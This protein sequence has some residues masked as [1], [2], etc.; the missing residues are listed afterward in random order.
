MSDVPG[1]GTQGLLRFMGLGLAATATA[2]LL[3]Y[4]PTLQWSGGDGIRAM[5]AGCG[6]ALVAGWIGAIPL[7]FMGSLGRGAA[8][9]VNRIL[10]GSALRM[11]VA[12]AL[13]LSLALGGWLPRAPLLV[14]IAVAYMWTLL[15]DT[16]YWVLVL[17][18]TR[19]SQ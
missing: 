6:V 18:V 11:A 1:G 7:C 13:T 2:A 12:L 14:W 10:A 9:A 5:L 19:A 17:K 8:G 3:G 4:Y 15:F 16:L